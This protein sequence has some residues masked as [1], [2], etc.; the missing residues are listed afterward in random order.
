MGLAGRGGAVISGW[1]R[2]EEVGG[3]VAEITNKPTNCMASHQPT[4]RGRVGTER[5]LHRRTFSGQRDCLCLRSHRAVTEQL[6]SQPCVTGAAPPARLRPCAAA[7]V[8][9]NSNQRRKT[10]TKKKQKQEKEM[11]KNIYLFKFFL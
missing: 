9:S 4:F 11:N 1:G 10:K 6:L 3:G 2:E 8:V 7:R 5:R